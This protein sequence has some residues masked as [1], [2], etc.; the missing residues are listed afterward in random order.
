MEH[1]APDRNIGADVYKRQMQTYPTVYTFA[2][3][4]ISAHIGAAFR[5]LMN[6]APTF[7][8]VGPRPCNLTTHPCTTGV[9]TVGT[10]QCMFTLQ[11]LTLRR[12]FF[13]LTNKTTQC[14]AAGTNKI[15]GPTE[16]N[17][18]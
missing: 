15:D 2:T 16:L 13:M 11:L 18:C 8:T 10:P 14:A 7:G 6:S 17:A 1:L 12:H 5:R 3:A 9:N 4:R